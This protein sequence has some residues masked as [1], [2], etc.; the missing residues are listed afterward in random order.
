MNIDSKNKNKDNSILDL[1]NNINNKNISKEIQN[2]NNNNT[3]EISFEKF[4][5]K[6]NLLILEKKIFSIFIKKYK[7]KYNPKRIY[8]ELIMFTLLFNK[9]TH[10]VSV[11]KDY[12]IYDYV[13]EFLK[14]FYNKIETFER[15]P[16]FAMFYKNYLAFFCQPCFS[17]FI[18]NT[19]IQKNREKKAKIFYNKN[20]RDNKESGEDE[21]IIEDTDEEEDDAILGKSNIEKTIFNDTIKRKIEQYSPINNSMALPESETHLNKDESG[22]LISFDN[23]NSLKNILI[24][25]INNKK[26][27]KNKFGEEISSIKNVKKFQID[28]KINKIQINEKIQYT[29]INTKNNNI[30]NKE[31]NNSIKFKNN[32]NIESKISKLKNINLQYNSKNKEKGNNQNNINN[33]HKNQ[34]NIKNLTNEK[35]TLS[36]SKN[37]FN[38]KKNK[39]SNV[40]KDNNIYIKKI[41]IIKL[42]KKRNNSNRNKNFKEKA[43]FNNILN[44]ENIKA[45]N[46]KNIKNI[47]K[48]IKSLGNNKNKNIR[49]NTNANS[50]KQIKMNKIY[51]KNNK[52]ITSFSN[53]IN[54][55]LSE[56]II[57]NKNLI[58]R[59]NPK[60]KKISKND[61]NKNFNNKDIY[62]IN[63]QL[64]NNIKFSKIHSYTDLYHK[65]TLSK[66]RKL[67]KLSDDFNDIIKSHTKNQSQINNMNI[68]SPLN[69]TRKNSLSKINSN[70]QHYQN[71]N[72]SRNNFINH[73]YSINN[74]NT[75]N[76][77]YHNNLTSYNNFNSKYNSS[78]YSKNHSR[79]KTFDKNNLINNNKETSNK[80]NQLN[81]DLL[82][83]QNVE[84]IINQ[85]KKIKPKIMIKKMTQTSTPNKRNICKGRKKISLIN[86]KSFEN[87]SIH[88]NTNIINTNYNNKDNINEHY[89]HKSNINKIYTK[90]VKK[91][92]FN[93]RS[94]INIISNNKNIRAHKLKEFSSEYQFNYKQFDINTQKS[95]SIN[96]LNKNIFSLK[97][98]N[99]HYFKKNKMSSNIVNFNSNIPKYNNIV[100]NKEKYKNLR[101]NSMN[102]TYNQKISC[103][104]SQ[105]K[106]FNHTNITN[107]TNSNNNTNININT[108]INNK[109]EEISKNSL[110]TFLDNKNT[111]ENISNFEKKKSK[112]SKVINLNSSLLKHIHNVNININNQIN[113]NNNNNQFND[114]IPF[115]NKNKKK[116]K[117]LNNTNLRHIKQSKSI[118]NQKQSVLIN[119]KKVL[120]S[121][122]KNN[123]LDFNSLNSFLSANS[124]YSN[125]RNNYLSKNLNPINFLLKSN[126][127]NIKDE[128]KTVYYIN[129]FNKKI[130]INSYSYNNNNKNNQSNIILLRNKT[131]KSNN[132]V[133]KSLKNITDKI[134]I[135]LN[136]NKLYNYKINNINDNESNNFGKSM[137]KSSTYYSLPK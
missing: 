128:H 19:L 5:E 121:R 7:I 24:N 21:G 104:S 89:Y 136:N 23:E 9:N 39:Q 31:K 34:L 22:L 32:I 102:S 90:L 76:K 40:K 59:Y 46:N 28:E 45:K 72:K 20:F 120:M 55:N 36:S 43:N 80:N 77:N 17:N 85:L 8:N 70:F 60:K 42:N 106:G 49:N 109:E 92:K 124:N 130:N 103:D 62:N 97:S 35:T 98:N 4:R 1:N 3:I 67:S 133:L 73:Q 15:L 14:R 84:V 110:S 91:E 79:H 38:N 58:E 41:E 54:K 88:N 123:S 100:K 96:Y 131:K 27:Y 51:N 107:N 129:N 112:E 125:L 48:H 135:N 25:M 18:Y 66:E 137:K 71:L 127:S 93:N 30:K 57:K 113:I 37:I 16:K 47:I 69:R 117:K 116:I 115:N 114:I 68:F 87:I 6:P 83:T 52:N 44:T 99:S 95:N 122:N 101:I 64:S 53:Q 86:L 126:N 78:Y 75:R 63:Y 134:Y 132:E 29:K 56:K 94:K 26:K 13:D 11:F 119:K 81:F 108:P 50:I 33:L 12:M 111:K 65:K 74:N 10:L 105:V 2:K 118:E 82:K 61:M